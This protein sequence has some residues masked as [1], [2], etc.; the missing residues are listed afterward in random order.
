MTAEAAKSAKAGAPES[1]AVISEGMI[2][3][4][5]DILRLSDV[6]LMYGDG[7]GYRP[8]VRRVYEAML[9]AKSRQPA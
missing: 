5:V 1:G 3:A 6:D 9:R 2:T 8:L 7:T 4:G